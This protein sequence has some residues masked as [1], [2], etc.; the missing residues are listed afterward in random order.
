MRIRCLTL[1]VIVGCF[2]ITQVSAEEACVAVSNGIMCGQVVSP[3]LLL[4]RPSSSTP[5]DVGHQSE[6][7]REGR[8]DYKGS[9]QR[10]NQRDQNRQER[11][12]KLPDDRREHR[13]HCARRGES[14]EEC[15]NDRDRLRFARSEGW[16]KAEELRNNHRN[17]ERITW[18]GQ[19]CGCGEWGPQD[20]RGRRLRERDY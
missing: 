14:A 7:P 12:D 8:R 11:P 9:E 3:D 5:P 19:G 13:D 6:Q 1:A 10:S 4:R 2:S 15:R 18:P 20:R 16:R 17:R